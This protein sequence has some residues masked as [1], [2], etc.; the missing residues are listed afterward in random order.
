[1]HQRS[2][3]VK[4]TQWIRAVKGKSKKEGR[5]PDLRGQGHEGRDGKD[6]STEKGVPVESKPRAHNVP[7]Y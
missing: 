7:P 3:W 5:V 4:G 1:M 2:E 6:L